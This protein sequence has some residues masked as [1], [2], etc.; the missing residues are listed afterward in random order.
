MILI[1]AHPDDETVG[2]GGVLPRFRDL[3]IV[4][5][6][7]GAPA[8][9]REARAAGYP[10]REDYAAARRAELV[11]AMTVAGISGERLR[12]LGHT[13]QEA[14]DDL[15]G[16]AQQVLDLFQALGPGSVLTHPYEGG[17]RD[18]DATA[19]AVHAA[20]ALMAAAPTI[21]EFAGYHARPGGH[22]GEMETGQF[23][24]FQ[25]PGEVLALTAE[26]RA[27]K[28]S[29]LECFETQREMLRHFPVDE[30]RFRA[31]PAY[32]F[33]AAPHTGKLLYE[34]SQRRWSGAEWRAAAAAAMKT[35]GLGGAL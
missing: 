25:D 4:H 5:V 27:R 17:D 8:D 9:M 14:S 24:E 21:R 20:C 11:Q 6:T 34:S 33:T 23:L 18:H 10:R 2:A 15:A 3:V 16:L 7:D 19:F 1:A 31:A 12:T 13:G 26:E 35:L 29:M 28:I 22:D 30:E 32:D